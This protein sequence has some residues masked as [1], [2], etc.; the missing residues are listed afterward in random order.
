MHLTVARKYV[1]VIIVAAVVTLAIVAVLSLPRSFILM[2]TT[3]STRDSGLLPY[4][5]PQFTAD[6]GI[7][8]RYTAVGTGQ[9]LDAGR[10]GDVDVVMVHAPSLEA[11][12]MASSDGLCR[13]MIM[14]NRFVIVGP[15]D[16]PAG[17]G[18]ATSAADAFLRIYEN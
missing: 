7:D 9:A 8:V 16:D 11:A 2:A 17:T 13:N 14:Y 5:L 15:A 1:A 4:L 6:T 10:R 18:N 3:T 12:F